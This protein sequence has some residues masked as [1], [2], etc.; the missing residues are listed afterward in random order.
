MKVLFFMDV[1]IFGGCEKML[2]EITDTMVENGDNVEL[3]LIYRAKTNTYLNK[4]NKKVKIHFL[5]DVDEKNAFIK[6]LVFWINTLFPS[7]V[8]RKFDFSQYDC[9]I[10]FKDDYQTNILASKV[11]AKKIAWVHNITENSPEIKN[12]SFKYKIAHWIYRSLYNKYLK[13]F[14]SFNQ[15]I[16][17][18]EHAKLALSSRCQETLNGIVLYNYVNNEEVI[19]KSYELVDENVFGDFTFCYVG[20][21]SAEKGVMEIVEAF[22]QLPVFSQKLNLILIGEGYQ[23]DELIEYIRE[24]NCTERVYFLGAKSNPY[25]YI[26]KSDVIL[27]ASHKESFGLVVLESL[28]MGKCVVSTCCGG[29]EELIINNKTGY[30]VKDY[31]E[32]YDKLLQ[33]YQGTIPLLSG[34]SNNEQYRN[35]KQKFFG[36]FYQI[37]EEMK[38]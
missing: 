25:P 14:S 13:T 38:G 18:S 22:C 29:P 8:L 31:N 30:L 7:F 15:V 5:W 27:C 34:D 2:K 9:V 4:L 16:F 1:F 6:R 12:K 26:R 36:E 3:L 11:S 10:N 37:L 21:L 28:I 17:V 24:H 33:L 19:K 20:R 35:L 23:K 32:F